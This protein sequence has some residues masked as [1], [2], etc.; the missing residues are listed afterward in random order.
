MLTCLWRKL[1]SVGERPGPEAQ[2]RQAGSSSLR[3]RRIRSFPRLRTYLSHLFMWM[4]CL[5]FFNGEDLVE[6]PIPQRGEVSRDQLGW[7]SGSS[8]F[9]LPHWPLI[10]LM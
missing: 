5:L 7:G 4:N 2:N 10:L 6:C 3:N 9:P 8:A 1:W